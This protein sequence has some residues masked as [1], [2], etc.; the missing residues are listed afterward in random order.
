M[1]SRAFNP[2]ELHD[3]LMKSDDY[4]RQLQIALDAVK[5]APKDADLSRFEHEVW[6]EI[7]IRDKDEA[8]F[9][10]RWFASGFSPPAPALV[11]CCLFAIA[12]GSALGLTK[13]QAYH[14]ESSLL[15]EQRYVESI[16]PVLMGASHTRHDLR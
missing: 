9:W 6:S 10:S 5:D 7:A 4:E 3:F 15:D 8:P 16:H 14:R 2:S 13:A 12:A 11:A 1:L